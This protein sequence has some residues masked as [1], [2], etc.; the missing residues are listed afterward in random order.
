M[1]EKSSFW[2][3]T[4]ISILISF[5]TLRFDGKNIDVFE[6]FSL[7]KIEKMKYFPK[8]FDGK[9]RYFEIW[10]ERFL[11]KFFDDFFSVKNPD[12]YQISK[13]DEKSA[14][15]NL[16]FFEDFALN[17]IGNSKTRENKTIPKSVW[18][19]KSFFFEIW[20]V[21]KESFFGDFYY[22]EFGFQF[23]RKKSNFWN[24]TGSIQFLK[25]D[26]KI[27]NNTQSDLTEKWILRNL[28]VNNL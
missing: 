12:M 22:V 17:K 2:N 7:H 4:K 26:G 3:L 23:C 27:Q 19:E 20:R 9:K 25:F 14:F 18:R 24:L 1:T 11:N 16:K 6:D 5:K 13:Y 8:R 10:R 15:R 21:K 28:T